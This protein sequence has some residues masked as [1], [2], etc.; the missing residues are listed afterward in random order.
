MI[1]I[2]RLLSALMIQR[3]G[4]KTILLRYLHGHQLRVPAFTAMYKVSLG[5]AILI[6]QS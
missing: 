4:Q 1:K 5:N 6:S 3:L 2:L